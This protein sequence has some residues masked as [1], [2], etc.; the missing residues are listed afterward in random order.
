MPDS[1]CRYIQAAS[2]C[3]S[4]TAWLPALAPRAEVGSKC[5]FGFNFPLPLSAVM[6]LLFFFFLRASPGYPSHGDWNRALSCTV[7]EAFRTGSWRLYLHTSPAT[8][9][10]HMYA[11]HLGQ[12]LQVFTDGGGGGVAGTDSDVKRG[13]AW[14]HWQLV[15]AILGSKWCL[16]PRRAGTWS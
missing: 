14:G 3:D 6:G 11:V 1:S 4:P 13:P 2:P 16:G 12:D 10:M 5:H 9:I 15:V 8:E 7:R